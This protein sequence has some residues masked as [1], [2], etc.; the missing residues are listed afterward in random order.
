MN[1]ARRCFASIKY[2]E[3]APLHFIRVVMY[4]TTATFIGKDVT[5]H[6]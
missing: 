4:N 5:R 6:I 3:Y 2:G 1:G